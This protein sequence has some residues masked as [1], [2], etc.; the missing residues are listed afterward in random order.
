MSD[1]HHNF[2]PET[3]AAQ[4]LGREDAETGAIVPPVQFSTTF[5]RN[6]DHEKRSDDAFY[7]RYGS[8]T[9]AHAED[10][11]ASLENGTEGL[12]FASGMAACTAAMHALEMG[13]HI[14]CAK[15]VYHGVV[16][17]LGKFAAARGLAYDFF[18]NGDLDA[19]RSAIR[20]GKTKLVWIETPANPMWSVADIAAAAEIAHEAGAVLGVD[21]TCAT[22]VLTR[23]LDLGADIVC[24][25]ATKYLAGHSDVLAGALAV[26]SSFPL[27]E[28]IKEHRQLAGP[29]LGAMEGFLLTRGMRTLFLRVEKQCANAMKV[30]TFLKSHPKVAR[31]YYPGLPDDPFHALAS[32]QM[33]GGYGGMLS[34]EA[35]GDAAGAIKVVMGCKVWKPATSLGGVESLIEHRKTSEGTTPT[36][37]PETLIRLSTGIESADDLIAD[38]DAALLR[39]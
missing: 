11:I 1:T 22:P 17:W 20:P 32:R 13:D 4:A 23:P 34:F 10:L 39:L 30:A 25:A 28:R 5:T 14:V 31:V 38:L 2:A 3:R 21:S 16:A 8:P 15:T 6:S 36:D 33:Q 35:G 24:H 9:N 27:W 26:R 7:I 29:T 18:P 19:L 12:V 37:T